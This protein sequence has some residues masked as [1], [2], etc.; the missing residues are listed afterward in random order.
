MY[1]WY[2][3]IKRVNSYSYIGNNCLT[4]WP[5]CNVQYKNPTLNNRP[6]YHPT[7]RPNITNW[8]IISLRFTLIL[9]FTLKSQK[10]QTHVK[11]WVVFLVLMWC[12]EHM[13]HSAHIGH[14][15]QQGHNLNIQSSDYHLE[16]YQEI[17]KVL[18]FAYFIAVLVFLAFWF[19]QW[20]FITPNCD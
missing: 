17:A 5:I 16:L 15:V 12:G 7:I 8:P 10:T 20:H 2:Q 6:F 19:R 9:F 11:T 1:M 4:P 3:W 13:L 14:D 18:Q